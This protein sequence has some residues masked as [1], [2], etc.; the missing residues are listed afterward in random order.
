MASSSSASSSSVSSSAVSSSDASSCASGTMSSV[1]SSPEDSVATGS[2]GAGSDA[3]SSCRERA[4]RRQ[5]QDQCD[6]QGTTE[7]NVLHGILFL[8]WGHEANGR[9]RRA[10]RFFR[11]FHGRHV[12]LQFRTES[13]HF[14]QQ[15]RDQFAGVVAVVD[16]IAG[17]QEAN[18]VLYI[19]ES[20]AEGLALGR[21]KFRFRQSRHDPFRFAFQRGQG[22]LQLLVI[23]L[24]GVHFGRGMAADAGSE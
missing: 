24:Q 22:F 19:G 1:V 5:H 13:C 10:G 16:I 23:R 8:A 6:Q 12:Q 17:V 14:L 9:V 15:L 18:I 20:I 3:G 4:D 21:L 2:S 11:Q 7:R